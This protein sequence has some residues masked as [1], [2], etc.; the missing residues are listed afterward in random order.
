MIPERMRLEDLTPERRAVIAE[1]VAKYP[2]IEAPDPVG[3]PGDEVIDALTEHIDF[4][5]AEGV[6]ELI[7]LPD[8]SRAFPVAGACTAPPASHSSYASYVGGGLWKTGSKTS[9]AWAMQQI[10]VNSKLWQWM[11]SQW[12]LLANTWKTAGFGSTYCDAQ[13]YKSLQGGYTYSVTGGHSIWWTG[14]CFAS[15]STQKTFYY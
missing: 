2:A 5:D 13:K 8:G 7:E 11:G 12:Q 1:F 10:K 9:V 14:E 6:I 3:R 4:A 15:R